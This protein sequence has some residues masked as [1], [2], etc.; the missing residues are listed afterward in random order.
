M[1]TDVTMWVAEAERAYRE[2]EQDYEEIFLLGH[3][4][5]GLMAAHLAHLFDVHKMV[6]YAPAFLLYKTIPASLLSLL[7]LVKKRKIVPWAADPAYPLYG[8]RDEGDDEYL[9][10]E[11]WSFIYYRQVAGLERLRR[12]VLTELPEIRTD[13]LVFTGGEDTLVSA[14]SGPLVQK[15]MRGKNNRWVH[16]ERG[17]HLIP[18]DR[19]DAA[20]DL[21]MQETL[22]FLSP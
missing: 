7:S 10:K 8:E 2:L 5:G 4:M 18:Y 15:G 1:K 19:D 21:A 16:L 3:S 6:L 9:G 14:E 20:R 17:T 13:T 12:E 11:Y 22:L